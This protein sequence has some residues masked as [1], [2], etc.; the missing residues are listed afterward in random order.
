MAKEIRSV[1][2]QV[3]KDL[4]LGKTLL[5]YKVMEDWGKYVG[6]RIAHVTTPERVVEGKLIVKVKSSAWRNELTF[7]KREIIAKINE[8]FNEEIITDIIFK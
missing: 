2:E 3:I 1:V 5:Q 4:H 8:R 7:M 6:D